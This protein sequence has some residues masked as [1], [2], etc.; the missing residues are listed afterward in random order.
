MTVMSYRDFSLSWPVV[1]TQGLLFRVGTAIS[2][3]MAPRRY[4]PARDESGGVGGVFCIV[5]ET[6]GRVVANAGSGILRDIGRLASK[7]GDAGNA[8][9]G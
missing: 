9:V 5:S 3:I 7:A 8:F 1:I 6:T 4:D 2:A